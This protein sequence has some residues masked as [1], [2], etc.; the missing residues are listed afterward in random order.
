MPLLYM[1]RDFPLPA[2]CK[3]I[4][5]AG[6]FGGAIGLL[7]NPENADKFGM[8]GGLFTWKFILMVSVIVGCVFIYRMFCRF[9][10]PLGALYGLFNKVAIFGIKLEKKSCISCGR[11]VEACKMDI[12]RVGDMECISCGKCIPVC[13]TKAISW[14]GKSIILPDSE[15]EAAREEIRVSDPE[16][17]LT[18]VI[19]ERAI[20]EKKRAKRVTVI[21]A[22]VS[23][24]L[25]LILGV[26]ITYFNFFYDEGTVDPFES[27]EEGKGS[28][29]SG[30]TEEINAPLGNKVGN[31]APSMELEQ[32]YGGDTL[33][34][35]DLKGKIVV[36][37][38]WGTWCGPCK[39]EL[40]HFEELAEEFEEEAEFYI[41]HT[42]TEADTAKAYLDA[43][44][45][46]SKMRW[47]FD[48][49]LDGL[50]AD[51]YFYMMGGSS[52]YPRTVVIDENGIIS[53]AIDGAIS[54]DE[55]KGEITKHIAVSD[56]QKN[57]EPTAQRSEFIAVFVM[58]VTILVA[59]S[60]FFTVIYLGIIRKPKEKGEKTEKSE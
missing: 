10:C 57:E 3:Y 38:F 43:N 6:T 39:A 42:V 41:V 20:V 32:V 36:V 29:E 58:A 47:V 11:C 46:D 13:P 34:I 33:S 22:A 44:F 35:A 54:Y 2:F 60:T 55:L 15:I 14:K 27:V 30:A 45:P 19:K 52:Y 8:L 21:T 50:S 17:S 59:A 28:E 56:D 7:I 53:F 4:C 37:N 25:I 51:W 1:L 40:P 49:Q 16:S 18:V 5:P 24:I 26:A 12:R 31:K 9:L 23:A 48:K